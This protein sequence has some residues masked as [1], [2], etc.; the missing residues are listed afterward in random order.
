[1]L[2]ISLNREVKVV[3]SSL[4]RYL[5]RLETEVKTRFSVS[6]ASG[7][8]FLTLH[9]FIIWSLKVSQTDGLILI[10]QRIHSNC[11]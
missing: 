7:L 2:I 6:R 10:V 9:M 3:I 11:Y 4:H 1:M 5:L 8:V